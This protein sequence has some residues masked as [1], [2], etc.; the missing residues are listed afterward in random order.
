MLGAFSAGVASSSAVSAQSDKSLASIVNEDSKSYGD[1]VD[2]NSK[3]SDEAISVTDKTDVNTEA[4]INEERKAI[5]KDDSSNV[6]EDAENLDE[7]IENKISYLG[8][9]GLDK[10]IPFANK[11]GNLSNFCTFLNAKKVLCNSYFKEASDALAALA[12]IIFHLDSDNACTFFT[13]F[14]NYSAAQRTF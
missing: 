11:L 7:K 5:S 2:M 12:K 13:S 9:K 14:F 3:I 8:F 10:F 6:K 4:A 1:S